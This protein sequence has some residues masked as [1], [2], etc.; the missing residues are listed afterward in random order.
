MMIYLTDIM[1]GSK[2]VAVN[3]DHIV[4]VHIIN[5]GS[6]NDGKTVV[7]LTSGHLFVA[8]LD[9]EVVAMINNG[10]N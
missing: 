8:E 10:A 4:A 2:K 5:D 9:Y 7:N 6:E 3:T 1:N